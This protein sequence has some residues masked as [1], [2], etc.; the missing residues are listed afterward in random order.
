MSDETRLQVAPG[1]ALS[2]L[3]ARSSLIARGRRDAANLAYS[4][5][6]EPTDP[7]SELGSFMG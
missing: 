7:L 5:V 4:S 3:T 2:P 1:S 6:L